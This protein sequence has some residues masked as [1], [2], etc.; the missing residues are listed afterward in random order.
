MVLH[1]CRI[2]F[3]DDLHNMYPFIQMFRY[4]LFFLIYYSEL[5][6]MIRQSFLLL[7]VVV[8]NNSNFTIIVR[9]PL[10]WCIIINYTLRERRIIKC[11]TFKTN[12]AF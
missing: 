12:L 5:S 7:M 4:Q 6:K 3:V 1:R 9:R 10:P 2:T 11:V 8:S